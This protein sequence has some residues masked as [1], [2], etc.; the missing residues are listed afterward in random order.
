M[1]IQSTKRWLAVALSLGIGRARGADQP[2][3]EEPAVNFLDIEQFANTDPEVTLLVLENMPVQPPPQPFNK[4]VN[5]KTK[6]GIRVEQVDLW[7]LRQDGSRRK[8]A[9]G[10]VQEQNHGNGNGASNSMGGMLPETG[11][12]SIS[13]PPPAN[14]M[15]GGS[16]PK[17]KSTP[18]T[19]DTD[20]Q[21]DFGD[22]NIKVNASSYGVGGS[23]TIMDLTMFRAYASL[24]LYL[25]AV[26][27]GNGFRGE[28]YS[29]A[30]GVVET[31]RDYD[32]LDKD[33]FRD[34]DPVLNG[35]AIPTSGQGP[36]PSFPPTMAP[37]PTGQ[38]IAPNEGGLATGAIIGIA[39]ACGVFGLLLIGAGIWFLIRR[40][41]RQAANNHLGSPGRPYGVDRARTEDLIAEKEASAGGADPSPHSPYSDDG[42]VLV[43]AGTGAS[44]PYHHEGS[45]VVPA[46]V[47]SVAAPVL[48][49][50]HQARSYTP[51]S[52][53]GSGVGANG[54][55]S[56]HAASIVHSTH[57]GENSRAGMGSPTAG[58]ATPHSSLS[59]RYAHLVEEGMT[60]D[61]IRRLEDE[62]RQL[63]AAIEQA[64]GTR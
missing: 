39:V 4:T 27:T 20:H 26:W 9:E 28:S 45:P 2:P 22:K 24:P 42:V 54:S 53:H 18:A 41:N 59:P 13:A 48:S 37:V 21:D 1:R 49:H 3:V 32:E 23:V 33:R 51:Y 5:W 50:H 36:K 46:G 34:T 12:T 61:E 10:T 11:Q 40:R 15:L 29:R 19:G 8:L 17:P 14:S 6:S 60:E 62:E 58:R 38:D 47:G 35:T 56:I 63:D 25:G 64:R 43:P 44:G 57:E 7:V 52:D 30:F 55:P 31:I 16:V